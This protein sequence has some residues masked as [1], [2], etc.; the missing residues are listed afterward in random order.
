MSPVYQ[1]DTPCWIAQCDSCT[2]FEHRHFD[3]RE[4]LVAEL[5]A[6][7]WYIPRGVLRGEFHAPLSFTVRRVPM[8]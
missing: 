8:K 3:T 4:E 1:A 2:E 7:G 5:E 6:S